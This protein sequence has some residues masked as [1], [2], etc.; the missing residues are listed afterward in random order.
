VVTGVL[1]VGADIHRYFAAASLL[2]ALAG[3]FPQIKVSAEK[4]H[5]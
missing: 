4:L 3:V 2:N 1:V 5:Q